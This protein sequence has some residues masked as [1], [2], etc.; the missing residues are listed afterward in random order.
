[1][2]KLFVITLVLFFS[3]RF[4]A[5]LVISNQGGTATALVTAMVGGGLTVSN[6]TI[7]CPS[8]AY[9]TFTNGASTNLGIPSGI[10][11]ATGNVNTL[12]GSGG[13]FWSANNGT[14][15]NDA[16]LGS[17][18]PLADYDCCIL[19]FDVVP[20]C[21]TLRI[22]FVFGSEEYPEWVSS[23]YNDAFGFF[24]TG[25][26]PSGGSYNNTNVATLPNNTTI[27]S[28]D[29]VNA[30]LNS[31]YYVNNSTGTSSV[32]DAFTTVLTRDVAVTPCQTYHFKLAIADAGDPIY[33]SG[34]FIDFLDCINSVT[35]TTAT[36]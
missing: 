7:N 21:T 22:R 6:A 18:E 16:Q 35:S 11:L 19:E 31:A 5:Q 36:T 29:N 12:N 20:S 14:T 26:N 34:V 10:V 17:L 4:S 28:I 23:G 32:L 13:T 2:K 1:M 33:D 24:V 25:Q 30:N 15:C 9:G 3:S 27:V 8:N